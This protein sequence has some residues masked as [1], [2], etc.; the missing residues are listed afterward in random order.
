MT[1]EVRLALVAPNFNKENSLAS[2]VKPGHALNQ[3]LVGSLSQEEA[4]IFDNTSDVRELFP[5]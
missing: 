3:P 1:R 2:L 4:Q 5:R